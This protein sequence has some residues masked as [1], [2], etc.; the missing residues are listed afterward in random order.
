MTST[1]KFIERDFKSTLFPLKTNLIMAKYHGEEISEYIYQRI[2]SDDH[3]GD[4]F[5]SQQKV[6]ATK[7]RGHLTWIIH[8]N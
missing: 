2:L 5:L 8:A 7:P 1:L 6:Y 3:P 4:N